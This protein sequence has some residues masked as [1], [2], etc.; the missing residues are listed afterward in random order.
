MQL[1]NYSSKVE[2]FDHSY[3]AIVSC[4]WFITLYRL[5]KHGGTEVLITGL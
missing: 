3:V 1:T 5:L 2:A 4:A